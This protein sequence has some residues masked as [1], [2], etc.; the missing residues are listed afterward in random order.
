MSVYRGYLKIIQKNIGV[1]ISYV[2]IFTLICVMITNTIPGRQIRTFEPDRQNIMAV[3]ED[4]SAVS[5]ALLDCLAADNNVTQSPMDKERLSR[6]LYSGNTDYVLFIPEGFGEKLAEG[7][8]DQLKIRSVREP[9]S[10]AGYYLDSVT[11]NFMTLVSALL[12][13]GYSEEEAAA[14][15][16]NSAAEKAEVTMMQTDTLSQSERPYYSWLFVYFPY[17]YLSVMIYI[18]SYVMMPFS[19]REIRSRIAAAPVPPVRQALQAIAAFLQLFLIFWAVTLLLPLM[20]KGADFYTSSMAGWYLLETLALL[21]VSAA[22]GFLIGNFVRS[23]ESVAALANII[24]LGLCFLCGVFVPLELMGSGIVRAAHF[25]PVYW[26]ET[27]VE[28]LASSTKLDGG[29]ISL[30]LQSLAIQLAYALAIV[31][32]TLFALKKRHQTV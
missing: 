15:A 12:A 2:A 21:S 11:E 28:T 16:K 19:H 24:S 30:L 10:G 32:M 20:T 31:M 26:F 27:G 29:S 8:A 9:G 1:L 22:I 7:D 3:D 14:L 17:L 13:S 23:E 18:I 6:L 25:L 4:Q 5:Q